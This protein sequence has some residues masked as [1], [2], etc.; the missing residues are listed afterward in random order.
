MA[1]YDE[2]LDQGQWLEDQGFAGRF[3]MPSEDED[4][5]SIWVCHVCEKTIDDPSDH[6]CEDENDF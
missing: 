5:V 6:F 2:V 4:G 1:S 3:M